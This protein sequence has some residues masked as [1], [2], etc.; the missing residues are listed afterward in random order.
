M[1]AHLRARLTY[2]NVTA[3]LALFVAL[4]GVSYAAMTVTGRD[5]V[6]GSLSGRDV[7]DGSLGVADFDETATTARRRGRR[8]PRGPRGR[9][10]PA[11]LPGPAGPP[12]TPAATSLF[13]RTNQQLHG[14][15]MSGCAGEYRTSAKAECR[16]GERAIG[17]GVAV[18]D[19]GPDADEAVTA[20]QPIWND[21]P[22][23]A[24]YGWSGSVRFTV[25]GDSAAILDPHVWVVCVSP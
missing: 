25:T 16:V 15:C 7:R 19:Y 1:P 9:R 6:D 8:G 13:V 3:T 24:P 10:G 18:P 20:S 12:G 21:R 22:N 23:S 5:V 4:G 2:A 14:D 17:G 11:G